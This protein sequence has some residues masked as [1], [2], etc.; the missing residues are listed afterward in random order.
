[1]KSCVG[2]RINLTTGQIGTITADTRWIPGNTTTPGASY[3]WEGSH[4]KQDQTAGGIAAIE[5]GAHHSD[6]SVRDRVVRDGAA[7][8][9]VACAKVTCTPLTH[10]HERSVCPPLRAGLNTKP[11]LDPPTGVLPGRWKTS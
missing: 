2:G 3:G 11:G 4:G 10:E 1:M 8:V 5:T 6:C 9:F 7:A